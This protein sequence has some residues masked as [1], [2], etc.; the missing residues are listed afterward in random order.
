M[1]ATGRSEV[2]IQ[3]VVV[4]NGLSMNNRNINVSL[5]EEEPRTIVITTRSQYDLPKNAVVYCS[6]N[7]LHKI[8][9]CT[10]K[11]WVDVRTFFRIFT[12]LTLYSFLGF[13]FVVL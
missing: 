8:D 9:P 5:G 12:L 13:F 7:Q 4:Q 11:M 1:S 10:F 3:D 2:A 6:F